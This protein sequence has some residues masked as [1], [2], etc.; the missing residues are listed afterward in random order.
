MLNLL[1][2]LNFHKNNSQQHRLFPVLTLV[3][4]IPHL[5]NLVAFLGDLEEYN[6]TGAE[7]DGQGAQD[8]QKV[9]VDLEDDEL[10]EA[11]E[12]H[13]DGFRDR[14]LCR[15]FVLQAKVER[16]LSHETYNCRY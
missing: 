13:V 1:I 2:V 11:G 5:A 4:F 9:H 8:V 15:I 14:Y 3:A 6:K 10:K 16:D 7:E 12:E